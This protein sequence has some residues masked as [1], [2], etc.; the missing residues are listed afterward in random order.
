MTPRSTVTEVTSL[1]TLARLVEEAA[2]LLAEAGVAETEGR[3]D[4]ARLA[5]S[6]LGWDHA[7][8]LTEQRMP[9]SLDFSAAFGA[10]VARRAGR[11]PLA[12]LLGE[13]EFYG[14]AFRVSRDVLIPRPE[15][16][17]LVEEALAV[18]AV[19]WPVAATA[20]TS[21]DPAPSI[22]DMGTGSGCIA[23]TLACERP[24]VHIT[25]TDVSAS[26]LDLARVNAA[27]FGADDRVTFRLGSLL[28]PIEGPI[29]LIVSNPPYVAE[30]DRDALAP[31]VRNHEPALALFA[32]PDGLDVIRALVREAARRLTP[33]GWLLMEI[34]AGQAD[35]ASAIVAEHARLAVERVR[36]D[37]QG[38]PRI[39]SI[40][41]RVHSA[42]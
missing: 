22:V 35:A 13:R 5:R 23:I 21:I 37:L 18:L 38:I 20:G 33:E 32:G 6:L 14:R 3:R 31:E 34:G 8:W 16:E 40:R 26:A 2:R 9:A 41:A 24:D 27:L 7:R 25:A 10:L 29:A 11:E 15:T 28:G 12:H 19:G 42:A 17:L 36:D 4:A 1:P 30:H 39:L